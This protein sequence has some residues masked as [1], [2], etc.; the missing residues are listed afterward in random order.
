MS[1]VTV[2][3][4][5]IAAEIAIVGMAIYAL[6]RGGTSLAAGLHSSDF[7]AAPIAPLAAGLTP[8]VVIDDPRSRVVVGTSGDELVHVRDLTRIRGAVF[9][10]GPYPHLTAA[11]TADG[12]RIARPDG[13]RVTFSLFDI[14]VQRIEVDVPSG[15]RL[16]IA[17]CEGADVNGLNG[18][19]SV[20]SIDG[21]VK[22][23][24]LRGSVDA[25]SDDGYISATNVRGDRLAVESMDGHLSLD[26]VTVASLLGTTRDGRIEAG[27]LSVAND[28]TLQTAD[29]SLRVGFAPGANLTVDASTRDGKITVDGFSGDNDSS[30]QRTI[31]LGAGT[32]RMKLATDDG[33]IHITTNGAFQ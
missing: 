30:A 2:V 8:H 19:V 21:H 20:H 3:A 6:G 10:S 12:V 17:R 7:A 13:G 11:R 33:S 26:N 5:L 27:N 4:M 9:S 22:L 25:R 14:S 31:R 29:G 28:A 24:D 32:G 18:D 23:S 1:R 15:S 16:E